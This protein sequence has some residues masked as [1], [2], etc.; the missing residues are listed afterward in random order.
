MPRSAEPEALWG[1][2]RQETARRVL[3][4]VL[5]HPGHGGV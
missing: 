3:R 5:D 4:R 1:A 2:H